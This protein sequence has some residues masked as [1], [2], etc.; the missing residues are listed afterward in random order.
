MLNL[1]THVL[2]EA[3]AGRLSA[4]ETRLLRND[5][6]SVSA[7]VLWEIAKLAQLGRIEVDL[8]DAEVV[9]TLARVQ[10][11]PITAR[12]RAPPPG[13]MSRAIPPTA[14]RRHQPRPSRAARDPR[15]HAAAVAGGSARLV[16]MSLPGHPP[17]TRLPLG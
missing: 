4:S 9:R 12:S 13:S 7:I 10:V 5:R 2:L 8:D 1:D 15:P 3:V 17:G 14:D 16:S 11:W 6:W